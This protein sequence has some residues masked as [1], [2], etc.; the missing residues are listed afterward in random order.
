[1]GR[2]HH[3]RTGLHSRHD[4][5]AFPELFDA[6]V[7]HHQQLIDEGKQRRSVRDDDDGRATRFGRGEGG[8]YRS[9]TFA[10]K[11][12]VGF[13]E[14]NVFR[15]AKHCA[16]ESD[17][18]LLSTREQRSAVS[19][20][21]IV[22]FGETNNEFVGIGGLCRGNDLFVA[23]LLITRNVL[24]HRTRQQFDVLRH[25]ADMGPEIR[26]RPCGNIDAVET[27]FSRRG[28]PYPD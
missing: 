6:P 18:L 22:S 9:L 11:I 2:P 15:V 13:I 19:N 5:L 27:D 10:I 26:A 17:P 3:L 8:Q 14:Y 25:V 24:A 21:C 12:G 20:V 16:G 7:P 23:C 28:Q 1:M 4:S